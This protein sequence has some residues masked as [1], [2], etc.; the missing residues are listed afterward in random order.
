MGLGALLAT[1]LADTTRTTLDNCFVDLATGFVGLISG[2][3]VISA[4]GFVSIT[5]VVGAGATV[6]E[7]AFGSSIWQKKNGEKKIDDLKFL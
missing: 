7:I 5:G 2:F 4:T 1:G 3:V 6:L